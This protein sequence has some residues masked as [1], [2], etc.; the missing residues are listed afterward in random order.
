MKLRI[1]YLILISCLL[2]VLPLTSDAVYSQSLTSMT[3]SDINVMLD[4]ID[5]AAKKRNV[6]GAI[7]P[8]AP[9]IKI[10]LAVSNPGTNQELVLTFTKA[11]Y[12]QSLRTNMRRMLAYQYERK[13]TRIKIYDNQTAMVT[14]E[15]Y[16]TMKLSQGTVRAASSEVAFVGLRNGKLIITG[17]EART[18]VY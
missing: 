3:E 17:I 11:Q 6:A 15:V 10:K 9:D 5:R 4:G 16:E 2:V 7:A 13:N 12:A 18:R 14:S 8:L 1:H